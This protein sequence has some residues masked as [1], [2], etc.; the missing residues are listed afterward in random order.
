VPLV[1]SLAPSS[2]NKAVTKKVKVARCW[3]PTIPSATFSMYGFF[4]ACFEVGGTP[5]PAEGVVGGYWKVM[6][7]FEPGGSATTPALART[8]TCLYLTIN[9]ICDTFHCV[10]K[11]PD[12]TVAKTQILFRIF[13]I[14][15]SVQISIPSCVRGRNIIPVRSTRLKFKKL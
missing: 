12:H 2:H 13:N 6:E 14:P 5:A 4:A 3:H 15:S 9:S 8:K 1:S 10:R 7:R 11:L